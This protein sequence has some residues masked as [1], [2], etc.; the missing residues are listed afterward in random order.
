VASTRVS[1][2]TPKLKKEGEINAVSVADEINGYT[3]LGRTMEK[4]LFE[5]DL[6]E[7]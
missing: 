4:I 1:F 2:F 3:Q 6:G 7:G 5:W